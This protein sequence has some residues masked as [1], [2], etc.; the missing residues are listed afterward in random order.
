LRELVRIIDFFTFSISES[1]TTVSFGLSTTPVPPFSHLPWRIEQG[2][3]RRRCLGILFPSLCHCFGLICIR[4]SLALLLLDVV[5]RREVGFGFGLNMAGDLL[6]V[7]PFRLIDSL[8][9]ST[10]FREID[11]RF[12]RIQHF[13][14]FTQRELD[15]CLFLLFRL[16]RF[17]KR[18]RRIS[19]CCF[20]SWNSCIF[21]GS[22]LPYGL[23]ILRLIFQILNL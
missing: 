10:R 19:R 12:L 2:Y 7:G 15:R 17:W 23:V 5:D 9:S 20:G 1:P 6:K 16:F 3:R 18:C 4:G 13:V 22:F 14:V 8:T 11:L 21:C